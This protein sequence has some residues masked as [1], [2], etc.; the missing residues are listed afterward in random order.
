MVNQVLD[1][2]PV[3]F[4]RLAARPAVNSTNAGTLLSAEAGFGLYR[5][6]GISRPS[7]LLYRMTSEAT[8]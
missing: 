6:L 4:A 7:K 5:M 3:T 1:H 8:K 2:G